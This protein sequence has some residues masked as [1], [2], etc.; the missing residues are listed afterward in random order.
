[1]HLVRG[2]PSGHVEAHPHAK[3]DTDSAQVASCPYAQPEGVGPST[4]VRRCA[5]YSRKDEVGPSGSG[6]AKTSFIHKLSKIAQSREG[7]TYHSPSVI[8][9][10]RIA[11]YDLMY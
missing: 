3:E 7:R 5:S 8:C 11:K 10:L 9:P 2:L 6:N 4:L 1:M